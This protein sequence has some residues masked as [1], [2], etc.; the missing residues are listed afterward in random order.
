MNWQIFCKL[1]TFI[2]RAP[3]NIGTNQ[4]QEVWGSLYI[5]EVL[6]RLLEVY[7]ILIKCMFYL[8]SVSVLFEC[9]I[10]VILSL[11]NL[12]SLC[13]VFSEHII[14]KYAIRT[15]RFTLSAR[16]QNI[17]TITTAPFAIPFV[18]IFYY[19]TTHKVEKRSKEKFC[20]N[21]KQE[22]TKHFH[23]CL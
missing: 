13:I 23:S 21:W 6:Y 2:S 3:Q 14:V 5:T 20:M 9:Y 15:I 18:L 16:W 10:F 22:T 7:A 11:L 19:F 12:N 8:I 4:F 1:D 17:M